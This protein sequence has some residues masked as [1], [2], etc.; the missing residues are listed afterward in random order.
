MFL[1]KYLQDDFERII[2]KGHLSPFE[3]KT[4]LITGASGY[5]GSWLMKMFLYFNLTAKQPCN[6][7]AIVRNKEKLYSLLSPFHIKT[8]NTE[9]LEIMED[10][11]SQSSSLSIEGNI[12][13]I[14]HCAAITN[15]SQMIEHPVEVIQTSINGSMKLLEL[16]REK[17]CQGIVFLS[18]MEVF[19]ATTGHKTERYTENELGVIPLNQVRSCYPESKRMVECLCKCYA[20]EYDVPVKTARLAQTF[21][22]ATLPSEN[23]IFA[24]LANCAITSSTFHMHTLGN[25]YGNYVYISDAAEAILMLLTKGAIGESYTVCNE[26]STMQIKEMAM[27]VANELPDIHFDV[28]ITKDTFASAKYA[29]DTTLRLSSGKLR[30]LGWLPKINLKETYIRMIN[31]IKTQK[32]L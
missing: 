13:Y 24:Q 3:G 1:S 28:E 8:N 31:D 6:I 16:A 2:Q 29:P 26:E 22:T 9:Y 17:K 7:I 11:L 4:I 27:M 10:D 23:R 5:I 32:G 25:S 15:S 12:D 21:G 14:I 19:G 30:A 18:S 20:S